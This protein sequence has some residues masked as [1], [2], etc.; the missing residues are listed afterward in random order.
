MDG[1]V[2]IRRSVAGALN[3][4]REYLMLYERRVPGEWLAIADRMET[5]VFCGYDSHF[6][7]FEPPEC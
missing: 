4:F 6:D 1:A 2:M 3:G 5:M 7:G